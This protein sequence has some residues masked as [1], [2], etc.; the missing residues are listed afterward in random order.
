MQSRRNIKI[1][2]A[3]VG[4]NECKE[5]LSVIFAEK[6]TGNSKLSLSLEKLSSIAKLFLCS[7]L[8]ENQL[9]EIQLRERSFQAFY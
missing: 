7:V 8:Y 9:R 3:I 6:Q 1:D 4:T 2:I 5:I